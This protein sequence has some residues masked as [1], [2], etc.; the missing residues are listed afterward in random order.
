[1]PACLSD[2]EGVRK[3]GAEIHTSVAKC[4][5]SFGRFCHD[6]AA[7]A[8]APKGSHGGCR[9]RRSTHSPHVADLA[10]NFV[11]T[12]SR[13]GKTGA[14]ILAR[15]FGISVSHGPFVSASAKRGNRAMPAEP[16]RSVLRNSR[17]SFVI[18]SGFDALTEFYVPTRLDF[19]FG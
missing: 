4:F 14:L 17:L 3:G 2:V 12:K 16:M 15:I 8:S 11:I 9:L 13:L 10:P 18:F 19:H 6:G 7:T 5:I 1:M